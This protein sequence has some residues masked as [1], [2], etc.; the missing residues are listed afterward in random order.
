M[1]R[2]LLA[3]S[4]KD[5]PKFVD[6]IA[7]GEVGDSAELCDSLV[8]YIY[9]GLSEEASNPNAILFKWHKAVVDRTGMGSIVRAITDRK[10]V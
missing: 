2:A 9:K 10:A 3:V 7:N 5:I 6:S 8:K 4:E 1:L